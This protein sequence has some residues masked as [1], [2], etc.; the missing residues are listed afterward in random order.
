DPAGSVAADSSGN[1]RHGECL[2]APG[3]GELS[4]LPA[5]SD[6][7]ASFGLQGGPIPHSNGMVRD[8]WDTQGLPLGNA[9]RTLEAWAKT[10]YGT[11]ESGQPMFQGMVGY[12]TNSLR[13]GFDVHLYGDNRV[14]L[15]VNGDDRT[16]V[17]PYVV[18]NGGWHHIVV[19]YDGTT[20]TAYLDGQSLGGQT[21]GADRKSVV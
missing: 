16:Y 9:S 5:D 17:A 10:T 15:R 12:G 6:S 3:L 11:A 19:T 7:S 21:F 13:Q 8:R 20:A 14:V 1:N 2:G 18:T 4:G